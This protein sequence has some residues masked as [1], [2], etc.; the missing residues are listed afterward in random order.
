MSDPPEQTSPP[1]TDEELV[2]LV[3]EDQLDRLHAERDHL[4]EQVEQLEA[5]NRLLKLEIRALERRL[6]QKDE[7]RQQIINNYERLLAKR[8]RSQDSDAES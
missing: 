6:E 4:S 8:D 2:R 3:P 7:Q 5:E 1:D